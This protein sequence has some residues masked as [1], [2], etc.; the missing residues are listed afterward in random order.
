[1]GNTDRIEPNNPGLDPALAFAP[2]DN[3]PMPVKAQP[4]AAYSL[5]SADNYRRVSCTNDAPTA[6]TVPSDA[7]LSMPLGALLAVARDGLGSV[8]ITAAAGVTL[9][10]PAA[11]ATP[12]TV[13]DRYGAAILQKTAANA[14]YVFGGLT[15]A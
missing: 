4:V 8:T 2:T 15:K 7:T 11:F 14:W 9:T 12:V 3:V 1:M 13:A 10:K 5:T 6:V